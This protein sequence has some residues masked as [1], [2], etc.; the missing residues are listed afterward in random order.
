L[1]L[2]VLLKAE[3][4]F[5]GPLQKQSSLLCII[6]AVGGPFDSR[7]LTHCGWCWGFF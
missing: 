1:L 5:L 7:V 3:H 2:P 4:L 6:V